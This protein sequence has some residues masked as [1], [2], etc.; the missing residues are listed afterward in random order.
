LSLELELELIDALTVFEKLIAL[1]AAAPSCADTWA[2]TFAASM[3]ACRTVIYSSAF[4]LAVCDT[5]LGDARSLLDRRLPL[6]REHVVVGC[7]AS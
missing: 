4:A 5:D 6:L 2:P 3:P 7:N 1:S